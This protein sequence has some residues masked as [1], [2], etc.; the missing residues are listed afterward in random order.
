[1]PNPFLGWKPERV[2]QA[3]RELQAAARVLV[4]YREQ[5]VMVAESKADSVSRRTINEV[6]LLCCSLVDLGGEYR[7]EGQ[8]EGQSER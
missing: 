3:Q 7:G 1:M 4:T 6:A 8:K 5:L 2:A